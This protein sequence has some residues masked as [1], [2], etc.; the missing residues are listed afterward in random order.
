MLRSGQGD[1]RIHQI[2]I[3]ERSGSVGKKISESGLKDRFDLLVL[4][5]KHEDSK[6]LEFN[7]PPNRILEKGMTILLRAEKLSKFFSVI[8]IPPAV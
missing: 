3:T 2:A 7:P 1:V 8:Y 6:D 5:A 4:G